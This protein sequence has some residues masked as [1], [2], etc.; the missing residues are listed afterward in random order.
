MKKILCMI[1]A[2]AM[3][4]SF[5]FT[6]F[7]DGTADTAPIFAEGVSE[8]ELPL[9]STRS[10]SGYASKFV[11][12]SGSGSFTVT[13][14]GTPGIKAGITFK[15]SCDESEY[16]TAVISIQRPNGVYIFQNAAFADNEERHF[17][18]YFP[19]T[20]TYTIYYNNYIPSGATMHMQIWIY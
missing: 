7:A 11:S 5:S 13:V 18:F 1:M 19:S 2:V 4:F 3:V 14:T 8:L 15:T 10:L 12:S 20:G 9:P 6:A 17:S 16:A